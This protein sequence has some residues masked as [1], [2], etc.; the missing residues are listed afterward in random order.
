MCGK[1]FQFVLNIDKE[2]LMDSDT[3]K[4]TKV[5]STYGMGEDQTIG[6]SKKPNNPS[7]LI[8]GDQVSQ[9]SNY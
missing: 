8:S 6:D 9:S 1:T 2:N 3:Y 4:V 7:E 5:P